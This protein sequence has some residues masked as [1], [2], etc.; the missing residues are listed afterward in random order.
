M[1]NDAVNA[2]FELGAGLLMWLN[3]SKVLKDRQVH[4]VSLLSTGFFVLWGYWNLYYYPALLQPLSFVG[5]IMVV[6]ANTTWFVLLL[7]YRRGNKEK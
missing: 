6:V 5:G 2:G 3:V 1:S 4:G 7:K